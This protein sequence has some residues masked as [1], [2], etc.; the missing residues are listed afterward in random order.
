MLLLFHHQPPV[1]FQP[2]LLLVDQPE[3]LNLGFHL[4][5]VLLCQHSQVHI[6]TQVSRVFLWPRL[7]VLALL[8]NSNWPVLFCIRLFQGLFPPLLA[9]LQS[10][11]LYPAQVQVQATLQAS[12][13]PQVLVPFLLLSSDRTDRIPLPQFQELLPVLPK[14]QVVRQI[15][16]QHLNLRFQIQRFLQPVQQGFPSRLVD[17]PGKYFDILSTGLWSLFVLKDCHLN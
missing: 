10:Q 11:V 6:P 12:F 14:L 1:V 5:V 9:F 2:L 17:R 13:R 4:Y 7:Q 3:P 8:L 16:P 15:P